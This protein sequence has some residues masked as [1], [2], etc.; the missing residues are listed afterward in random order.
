LP[1]EDPLLCR[2]D[3]EAPADA[4]AHP[5][6]Q[7]DPTHVEHATHR[8]I[9]AGTAVAVLAFLLLRPTPAPEPAP[10]PEQV[11]DTD[12][13][14]STT[15]ARR[16]TPKPRYQSIAVPSGGADGAVAEVEVKKGGTVRLSLRSE[17]PGEIHIH[18]YDRYVKLKAGRTARV[19]FRAEIDGVF[20]VENHDTG[21]A[22][23]E[24]KVT[25]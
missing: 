22:V 18:G 8:L 6:S 3:V 21:V 20:E 12:E 4:G 13:Q 16:P 25:P 7:E 14:R 19:A 1:G 11:S 23:A 24:L 9:A 17:S 5:A 2:G 10:T 15:T